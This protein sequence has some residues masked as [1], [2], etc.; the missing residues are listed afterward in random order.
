MQHL[1]KI[2]KPNVPLAPD[3]RVRKPPT[4]STGQLTTSVY[5]TQSKRK[6]DSESDT[7]PNL[8]NIKMPNFQ[9]KGKKRS[10]KSTTQ[11]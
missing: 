9:N 1:G 11:D 5:W 2:S 6:R 8:T 4:N 10:K 7:P 3:T